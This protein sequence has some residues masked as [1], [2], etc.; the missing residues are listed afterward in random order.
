MNR[1]IH[2][3]FRRD[4][5]RFQNSLGSFADGDRKRAEQLAKAWWNFDDQLEHHH[6]GEHDI[7]WPALTAIGVSTDLLAQLDAEH[8]E[9]AKA[10]ETARGKVASLKTSASA[11]DAAAARDAITRLSDVM[12]AHME[13]EESETE[14][15]YLANRD[16]PEIKEMGRKFGKVSPARGG[17]FFAW[18]T[19]GASPEEMAAI[20]GE[21]P[22]PVLMLIGGIFGR[23]YRRDV[24]AVWKG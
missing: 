3:A 18:V 7:A 20:K 5:S 22:G 13:H 11:D 9:M 21:V 6:H 2:A 19:D 24:A 10:L 15:L 16:A 14:A 8:D 23:G 4:L 1:A 12:S 17:R